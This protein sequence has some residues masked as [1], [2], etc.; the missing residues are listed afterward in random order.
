[1]MFNIVTF[2]G[3][4]LIGSSLAR[5]MKRDNLA[6]KIV[7]CSRKEET[8]QKALELGIVDEITTDYKQAVE[9][10]DLVI[11]CVP[12]GAYST[13][14]KGI[15]PY[16]KRGTIVTDVGSVKVS[17][18]DNIKEY[19]PDYVDFVPGH[20]I[21]GTEFSGPEAGYAELFQ[22]AWCIL[23]PL[24][25]TS[26]I[27]TDKIKQLWECAGMRVEI[28]GAKIHDI[29]L[30]ITSHLPH[31]CAYNVVGM[32]DKVEKEL[33]TEI[34]KFSAT[35]FGDLTRVAASDPIMWRDI[36]LNNQD[37][38][39]DVLDKFM[40]ELIKFR[41]LLVEIDSDKL[42]EFFTTRKQIKLRSIGEDE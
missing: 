16:L 37:I 25:E 10:S 5:V 39:I 38:A 40:S 27:A 9:N 33:G 41:E 19:L 17:A 36:F 35:S 18:I 20:P 23:T 21:A 12:M 28:M 7:C 32:A 1:M 22:G 4:G 34:I 6:H 3:I 29:T 11:I 15:S 31:M 24:E 26:D 14:A 2:I 8:L 42:E 30:C 13:V